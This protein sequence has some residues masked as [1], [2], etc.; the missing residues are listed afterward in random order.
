MATHDLANLA[1]HRSHG[2][3]CSRNDERLSCLGLSYFDEADIGG[4]ARHAEYA[5]R[6]RNRGYCWVDLVDIVTIR[7]CVL[8]PPRIAHDE[9]TWGQTIHR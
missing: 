4:H 3:A 7:Q 5:K 6:S 8:L 2:T 1:D 9:I